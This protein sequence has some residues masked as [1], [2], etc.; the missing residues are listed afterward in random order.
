MTG[1]HGRVTREACCILS[2]PGGTAT[3]PRTGFIGRSTIRVHE[4]LDR[5]ADE[6]LYTVTEAIGVHELRR[7]TFTAPGYFGDDCGRPQ[8]AAA[9]ALARHW[10]AEPTCTKQKE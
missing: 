5:G 1:A 7:E 3:N 8:A 6:R 9:R 10:A 2:L 4:V